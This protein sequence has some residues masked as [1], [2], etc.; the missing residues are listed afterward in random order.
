MTYKLKYGQKRNETYSIVSTVM[1][2]LEK[3]RLMKKFIIKS[4]VKN[5][6]VLRIE[7]GQIMEYDGNAQ[8]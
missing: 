7:N 3:W 8:K 2:G 4:D 1:R 5:K 6:M